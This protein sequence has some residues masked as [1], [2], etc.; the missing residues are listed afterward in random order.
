MESNGDGGKNMSEEKT[1]LKFETHL[2]GVK[3]N[4]EGIVKIPKDHYELTTERLKITKQGIVTQK[5]SDI[6]LYKVKDSS[7]KQT[8]KDKLMD[9]GNIEIISSDESD[10]I[11][12]LKKIKNP[13]QVRE[14]I[15]NATKAAKEKAGV[16]YRHNI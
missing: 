1:L 15:R 7:V 12:V 4:T 6:E 11:I 3:G 13:H 10:P 5:L 9:I 8:M 14:Q 16:T 2:F